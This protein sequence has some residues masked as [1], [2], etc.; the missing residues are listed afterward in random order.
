M[1]FAVISKI[2]FAVAGVIAVL[3]L[4]IPTRPAD[5]FAAETTRRPRALIDALKKLAADNLSNLNPHPFY[6]FLHYSH[7]PVLERIRSVSR[8]EK[9]ANR[10]SN[11]HYLTEESPSR[12]F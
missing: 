5:R 11:G 9:S 7:P 4:N 10:K 6:V 1:Y 2:Y 12:P 8:I 3:S